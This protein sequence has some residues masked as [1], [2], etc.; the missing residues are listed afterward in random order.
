MGSTDWKMKKLGIHALCALLIFAM[1]SPAGSEPRSRGIFGCGQ[2][3]R[4]PPPQW[5]RVEAENGTVYF[6]DAATITPPPAV[7]GIHGEQILV[8]MDDGREPTIGNTEWLTFFC[9]R[10]LVWESSRAGAQP[11]YVPPR[12]VFGQIR[13]I[14]CGSRVD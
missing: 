7:L 14:A 5:E 8:Y 10:P 6:V 2:H 13:E 1:A 12:S 9:D 3:T 11:Q 4:C